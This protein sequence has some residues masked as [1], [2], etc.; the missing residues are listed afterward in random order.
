[1]FWIN[2]M[3]LKLELAKPANYNEIQIL[4]TGCEEPALMQ[5]CSMG[6]SSSCS[7]LPCWCCD[8]L[9]WWVLEVGQLFLNMCKIGQSQPIYDAYWIIF[10]LLVGWAEQDKVCLK[11]DRLGTGLLGRPKI[12]SHTLMW[13]VMYGHVMALKLCQ[14]YRHTCVYGAIWGNLDKN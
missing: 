9:Q 14:S 10:E 2:G 8:S 7:W 11:V 13:L 3:L 4:L 1:M 6:T 12:F 5:E